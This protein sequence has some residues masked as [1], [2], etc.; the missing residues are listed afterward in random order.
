LTSLVLCTLKTFILFVE[1]ENIYLKV[2]LIKEKSKNSLDVIFR[3]KINH[4]KLVLFLF[5]F[6]LT[7]RVDRIP[8][9][10]LK[11]I[12]YFISSKNSKLKRTQLDMT[13]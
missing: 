5:C 13:I 11:Q 10:N 7:L 2:N 9:Y 4:Y 3:L 1:R 12:L 8:N 6:N